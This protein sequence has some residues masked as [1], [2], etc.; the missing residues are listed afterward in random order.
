MRVAAPPK[1]RA[2]QNNAI[3]SLL[4]H[5]SVHW[6]F[7]VCYE[8]T[9]ANGETL[10]YHR[11]HWSTSRQRTQHRNCLSHRHYEI[12]NNIIEL[13][14]IFTMVKNLFNLFDLSLYYRQLLWTPAVPANLVKL[15]TTYEFGL[16]TLYKICASN[17]CHSGTLNQIRVL[18]EVYR[19]TVDWLAI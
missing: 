18:T 17:I 19:L 4:S 10:V 11:R 14:H 16:Q 15:L 1:W 13:F 9:L 6:S 3:R 12:L 2:Q 5:S 8:P 7:F